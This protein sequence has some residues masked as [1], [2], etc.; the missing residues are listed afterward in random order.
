MEALH[1][2][3]K[4]GAIHVGVVLFDDYEMLDVYGPLE[5]L[6]GCSV[7]PSGPSRGKVKL[8]F[9]SSETSGAVRP[10]DGPLTLTD[11]NINETDCKFDVLFIPG[12]MG[13]RRLSKNAE[14][15]AKLGRLSE[16]A[17]LVMTVCTG[18][19]L[20]AATGLLDGKSA[21]T[22][23]M[24]FEEI[25]RSHPKVEWKRSARWCVD[26]KF[27][28]SS[29]VAAGIDLTH[30]FV[31]ELFGA[32]VAKQTSKLA[33]YVHQSDPENDPFTSVA[34]STPQS[35]PFGRTLSLVLVVYDQP[36]ASFQPSKFQKA[37]PHE[38]SLE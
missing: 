4:Q 15:L 11:M 23:K 19:L 24:A 25:Q 13:T 5:L 36:L 34:P 2:A 38:V 14:F 33:E 6:A 16:K 10:K 31:E 32:K 12:G 17:S 22:N 7:L 1:S 28:T 27:Y 21:T 35:N 26:G 37:P 9:V 8:S 20:L 29:G 30:F 18:S 3:L